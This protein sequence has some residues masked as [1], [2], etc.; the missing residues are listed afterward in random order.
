V[1]QSGSG[2]PDLFETRATGHYLHV[3]LGEGRFAPARRVAAPA[4]VALS[5]PGTFLSDM[6]GDGFADLVV[7]GGRR[8]YSAATR[9]GGWAASYQSAVAPSVDLDARNVRVADLTG[10]GL[11]DVLRSGVSGWTFIENLGNG[12]WAPAR[13]IDSAPAVHLD[14]PRVHLADIDGDGLSDLVYVDGHGVTVWPSLGRGRFGAPYRMLGGP[15]FGLD[16]N[17]KD[18]RL[19]DLTGSGQADVLHVKDGVVR[20]ASTCRESH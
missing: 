1:R 11:P 15:R 19:V 3:N 16:Y 6:D 9:N 13:H 2:L 18:I 12:R 4:L 20:A 10:N 7:Q 5:D 8:V 17:P 14:D